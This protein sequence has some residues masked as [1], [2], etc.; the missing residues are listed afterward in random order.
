MQRLAVHSGLDRARPTAPRTCPPPTRASPGS[1]T[2]SRRSAPRRAPRHRRRC[3]PSRTTTPSLPGVHASPRAEPADA[4]ELV[5]V[6]RDEHEVGALVLV[7]ARAGVLEVERRAVRTEQLA[8]S[9][10]RWCRACRR[11]TRR[12]ARCA[13]RHRATRCSRTPDPRSGR[14]PPAARSPRRTRRAT[15]RR[16]PGRR[17]DRARGGCASRPARTRTAGR[18]RSRSPRRAP[19]TRRRRPSRSRPRRRPPRHARA[20][21]RSSPGPSTTGSMPRCRDSST[22]LNCSTFPPPDFGF[23]ISTGWLGAAAAHPGRRQLAQRRSC[24]WRARTGP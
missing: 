21:S 15:R 10:P 17:R 5:A 24:R 8:G 16:R 4:V 20:A 14:R 23:M 18:A 7:P 9:S 19:A 3:A 11:G 13:R 6:V 2:R 1:A 22:R 12:T